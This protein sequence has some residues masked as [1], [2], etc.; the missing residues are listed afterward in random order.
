MLDWVRI[1]KKSE[2]GEIF[3]FVLIKKIIRLVK[4]GTNFGG[5][6]LFCHFEIGEFS[7]GMFSSIYSSLHCF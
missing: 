5:E 2:R 3:K 1:L 6:I 7:V 4:E